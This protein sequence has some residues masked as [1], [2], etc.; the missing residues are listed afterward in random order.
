MDPRQVPAFERGGY[1]ALGSRT[2]PEAWAR[3]LKTHASAPRPA[4]IR[5]YDHHFL[6][7]EAATAGLGV[8]MSPEVL[9]ADDVLKGR[10]AAPAGFAADGS[11]YGLLWLGPQP[12]EAAGLALSRWLVAQCTTLSQAGQTV[13]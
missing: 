7:L 1:I 10:L 6:T 3:W 11:H 12:L 8:A 4:E 13:P 2:R 5:Y 9:A